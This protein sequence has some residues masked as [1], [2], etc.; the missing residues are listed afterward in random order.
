M[1]KLKIII[2]TI[3]FII[4]TILAYLALT[5]KLITI[6]FAIINYIDTIRNDTL[7]TIIK[8]IT[9]LG[10]TIFLISFTIF[11]LF[12]LKNNITKLKLTKNLLIITLLNVILKN[13]IK[14]NRPLGIA[15]ILEDSYSFPSGHAMISSA[16]YFHLINIIKDYIKNKTLKRILSLAVYI[17]I[18]LICFSRVYLGVHYFSDVICG[19]LFAISYT[20]I[21]DLITKKTN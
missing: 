13:I 2:A 10:G 19:L 6:D 4:F 1:K 11:L 15:L 8:A 3:S 12:I 16:F 18:L 21:F 5:N 14:R 9:F 17:L 20:N 7:T